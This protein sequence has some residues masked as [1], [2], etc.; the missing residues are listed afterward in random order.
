[1]NYKILNFMPALRIELNGILIG[2]CVCRRY[3]AI[4]PIFKRNNPML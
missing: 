1:M 4:A 3:S 2:N